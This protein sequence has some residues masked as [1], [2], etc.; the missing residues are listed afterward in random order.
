MSQRMAFTVLVSRPGHA[1]YGS[2]EIASTIPD[3][4]FLEEEQARGH[5]KM[6]IE[7]WLGVLPRPILNVAGEPALFFEEEPNLVTEA[8]RFLE[9]GSLDIPS[10]RIEITKP[11][12]SGKTAALRWKSEH[13]MTRTPFCALVQAVHRN[14]LRRGPPEHPRHEAMRIMSEGAAWAA[15][16]NQERVIGRGLRGGARLDDDIVDGV[17]F[18]A[19]RENRDGRY[20]SPLSSSPLSILG[21]VYYTTTPIRSF[22]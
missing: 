16:R 10:H 7:Q 21:C 2:I 5:V 19:M 14:A 15:D 4:T 9:E 3:A 17:V 1:P 6:I 11:R 22:D 8:G 18:F 13:M 20:G 12:Q